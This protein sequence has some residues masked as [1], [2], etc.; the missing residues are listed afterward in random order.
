MKNRSLYAVL[1]RF[2]IVA[3][4]LTALLVIA[5]AAAQEA[6]TGPCD[7]KGTTCSIDENADDLV[8]E[9]YT[10]ADPEG[11]GITWSVEGVDHASFSI[12]GGVLAFKKAPDYEMPGDKARDADAN[13]DPPITEETVDNV[14]KVTVVAT[15]VLKADQMPPAESESLDVTVTV[16][17][18]EE[19]GTITLDRLQTRVGATGDGVTASLT[20]PDRDTNNTTETAITT[21]VTWE[22]SIP[23]VNRPVLDNDD[24]WTPAGGGTNNEAANYT[25]VEGDAGSYLRVKAMYADGEGMGK[26]AYVMTAN[27]ALAALDATAT[28]NEPDFDEAAVSFEVAED[29]E[30]GT[31]V[32]TVK[33]TDD[34]SA[35]ILSHVLTANGDNADKFA[36]DIASGEITVAGGLNYEAVTDGEYEVTVTAYDPSNAASSP[37]ATVTITATDVNEA[38]GVGDSST[39][40]ALEQPENHDVVTDNAADPPTTAVV[41][42]TYAPTDVDGTDTLDPPADDATEDTSVKLSLGGVD[43]DSFKLG[44]P[45]TGGARALTFASS[46][47]FESPTDMGMDNTYNVSIVATDDEGLTGMKALVIKVTNVQEP[48]TVSILPVQPAIGQEVTAALTDEDGEFEDVKWQWASSDTEADGYANIEGATMPTYTPRPEIKADEAAGIEGYTGDEGKFLRA[49]VTYKDAA[50]PTTPDDDNTGAD[51]SLQTVMKVTTHAVRAVPD[52]NT[53]PYFEDDPVELKVKETAAKG[54]SAGTV[55][56][57]DDQSDVLT[58]TLSGGADM[59]SFKVSPGGDVTTDIELDYDAGQRMYTIEVTAAD[60]FGMSGTGTVTIEVEGVN[61]IP[62]VMGEVSEDGYDEKGMDPV[63]TFTATDE[64]GDPLKWDVE[65]PDAEDFSIDGGVLSFKKSPDFENPTDRGRAEDPD[66][67]ATEFEPAGNRAYLVTITATEDVA[68][69]EEGE[70]NMKGIK[71]VTVTV[72]NVEEDGTVTIT[73]RQPEVDTE[74]TASTT[75]PD[76]DT[77]TD[78]TAITTGVM[79]QW[80]IPKVNRP[81]LDNDD[82]W[83]D[84]TGTGNNQPGYTPN[85]N[86]EDNYLRVKASYTD[87]KGMDVAYVMSE[88]KVRADVGGDDNVAPAFP[89][90]TAITREIPE[91]SAEGTPVGDPVAASDTDTRDAGRLTYS[92]LTTGDA[93]SFTV[94]KDSGQLRVGNPDGLA[95]AEKL[96][97]EEGSTA[98]DGVYIVTV[99]VMD[100]AGEGNDSTDTI[101]VNITATDV[102]EAPGVEGANDGDDPVTMHELDEMTNLADATDTTT[103]GDALAPVRYNATITDTDNSDEEVS[104]KLGGDDASAFELKDIDGDG[105]GTVHALVFASD[106]NYES[107]ATADGS[108]TYKVDVIAVDKA[109]NEKAV[110]VTVVVNNVQEAGTVDVEP[111][112]PAIGREVT[113]E[114]DDEDGTYT[115]VKWQWYGVETKPADST[116][117]ADETI[118]F[119]ELVTPRMIEGATMSTYT[120]RDEIKDNDAT[121]DVDESYQ[122][123]EG[124]FLVAT[125]S[126]KDAADPTNEDNDATEDVDESAQMILGASA[127]AVR[128]VP[129]TNTDPYFEDDPVEL[130]VKENVGKGGSAGSV[131]AT[132]DENDS[133]TYTLSGGADMASF[134]V[135]SAGMVTT[136]TDLDYDAGQRMY[137]IEVTAAD[138]FGG[139]GT[140]TVT[141]EV[142][143]VN[144]PPSLGP[145]PPEPEVNV[146]PEFADDAETTFMVYE[147]DAGADVGTVTATDEGDVLAYSDDSDYFDVD[148]DGNITTAMALDYETAESH[149]VTI[150]ATDDDADDP[151]SAS[152]TVTVNVGNVEECEDAGATAVDTSNAGAMADC[153]ALL[154]SKATLMGDDAT[155][156]LN[157]SAN[158]PMAEWHGVRR[159]TA[160]GR[161]EWLYLHGVSAK[162]ATDDTDARAEVK[163]NGTIPAELGELTEMTR[164]YLHRNNLT[165]GIPTE[166]NGLTNLVWLRLYDN[167]LSGVVPDLSE[168]AS[169]ERFYV[170]QNDLTGGVPTALSNSVTHILVHRNMLTG[171]IPDLSEMTNLVWLGLYDNMLSGEIPASV[172]SIANLERLYLHGNALTGA[173]PMEIGNLASLTNLWLE[174]NMLSGELPSSLDNL[175]NLERVQIIG[176]DNAFTGCIP[177]ALANAATT[178]ALE[179]GLVVCP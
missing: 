83:Q 28:N 82:H 140:G 62:V 139:S 65:G 41:L 143:D 166:L 84:S 103:L 177:A 90:N 145:T 136:N 106:P 66:T 100:S 56:A 78:T 162:D 73:L 147:N 35:D 52:V 89:T 57:T 111:A 175:T 1:T 96:D 98:N 22:W 74:L 46:P 6:D 69:R 148:N 165:G 23:K 72:N 157:W 29:A 174:N 16:K 170:H 44:D 133:L 68:D 27:P 130:K 123:D 142:T 15:E 51:E 126:Y 36:I 9:T 7:D 169:L 151:L 122:G 49:T 2:G 12:E 105:D 125:V 156:M 30:V 158:T 97:K 124:D 54:S 134:K 40:E 37:A 10:S 128:A 17:N 153:E 50:P 20:D 64:D 81:V 120:P 71:A 86:D 70:T 179:T 127:N 39:N 132:D 159:L 138:P 102:D 109:G 161:V 80:S 121:E 93:A 176:G 4:V 88:F 75:D 163:L 25:P 5:P 178:D 31:V 144:E 60:P 129:G 14:Y 168:M 91:N 13:A 146:A 118:D 8:I 38:P 172:G 61:E 85:A 55:M 47:N 53:A 141:I 77:T 45:A 76:E 164:L 101:T 95:D 24:H 137:T 63:A 87:G 67:E 21:G 173:V 42:G 135:S 59:A 107:P 94:D 167:M 114:L 119:D 160:S 112:Q 33:A 131:S 26:T 108:N 152:I 154:A 113:A 34:D 11:Q 110:S 18:V 149:T 79:Y 43:A 48:G 99:T 32:G 3:A 116:D 155:R 104:L 117:D 19:P 150:T 92:I 58:Y 115:D 171:D